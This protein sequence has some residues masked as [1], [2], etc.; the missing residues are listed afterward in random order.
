MRTVL[1]GFSGWVRM[2]D[3]PTHSIKVVDTALTV[4]ATLLVVVTYLI[5]HR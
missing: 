4:V 2:Q 1:S 3:N 5:L